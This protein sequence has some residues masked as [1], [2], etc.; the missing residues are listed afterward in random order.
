MKSNTASAGGKATVGQASS[1]LWDPLAAPDVKTLVLAMSKDPNPKTTALL[2]WPG[3]SS[4]WG[5]AKLPTTPASREAVEREAALLAEIHSRYSD[6][7]LRTVPRRYPTL[8]AMLPDG[9]MVVEAL[10][11]ISLGSRYARSRRICSRAQATRDFSWVDAWLCRMTAATARETGPVGYGDDVVRALRSRFA[12]DDAIESAMRVLVPLASHLGRSS[13]PKAVV[14]GDLW[15]GNILTDD[16]GITGVV[17][18][19][20]GQ[21]VGEPIR[22]VARFAVTYALYLDRRTKPGRRVRGHNVVA[23]EWGAGVR[24]ALEGLGWFPEL[25]REFV[26]RNLRRLGAESNFWPGLMLLGLADIAATAD[27]ETWAR[28]HL[29]LLNRLGESA[30]WQT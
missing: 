22:D 4:P 15:I 23:G 6:D 20:S 7:I 10:P 21:L 26:Q 2:F 11:G 29:D 13:G 17:D 14:H 30:P 27:D 12:P 9:A 16:S 5:A 19:E 3:C 25:V 18:W 28:Q 1:L 8:E 24:Y